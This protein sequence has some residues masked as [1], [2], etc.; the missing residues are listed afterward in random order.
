MAFFGLTAL[1]NQDPFASQSK[2]FAILN[3]FSLEE[4]QAGFDKVANKAR[5]A[6]KLQ[7]LKKMR[8]E[9]LCTLK[10]RMEKVLNF[11]RFFNVP[12]P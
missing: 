5:T 3:I 1:G 4:F 12:P 11:P 2:S 6:G 9:G 10:L 8:G 7:F